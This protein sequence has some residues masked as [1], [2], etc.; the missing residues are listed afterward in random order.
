MIKIPPYLKKGDTIAITCP[1]GYME[2]KKIKTCVETLQQWGL[3][4]M[5][6]KKEGCRVSY[7]FEC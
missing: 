2:A 7:N 6:D 5:F 3:Q 1:A 4:V